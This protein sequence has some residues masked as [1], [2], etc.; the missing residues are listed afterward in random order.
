MKINERKQS[1]IRNEFNYPFLVLLYLFK[2]N[3][4][5]FEFKLPIRNVVDLRSSG[6]L[7]HSVVD[8]YLNEC[9]P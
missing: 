8:A 2:R 3:L 9:K 1:A 4:S 7:F 6:S 5:H